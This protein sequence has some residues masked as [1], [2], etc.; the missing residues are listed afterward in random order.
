M[1]P[2]FNNFLFEGVI[3]KITKILMPIN[4]IG[5]WN[6]VV[7]DSEHTLLI[8]NGSKHLQP[9]WMSKLKPKTQVEVKR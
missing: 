5:F 3:F 2:K 9:P 8:W 7:F 4:Q 1:K 6:S